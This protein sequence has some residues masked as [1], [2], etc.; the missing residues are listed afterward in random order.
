MWKNKSLI[1]T[2][3]FFDVISMPLCDPQQA[4]KKKQNAET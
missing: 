1:V 2:R 4:T 3:K